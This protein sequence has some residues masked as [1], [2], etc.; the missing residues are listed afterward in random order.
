MSDYN[1]RPDWREIDRKKDKSRHYG[2]HEEIHQTGQRPNANRWEM[3]RRK[4]ALDRLFRG[5]KG[6]LEHDRLLNKIHKSYK[7]GSF[8][9][10]IK[11]YIDKYGM[12][13]DVSTLLIILDS[14]SPEYVNGAMIKLGSIFE[15]LTSRQKDDVKR[16]LSIIRMADRSSDVRERADE[17]LNGL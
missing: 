12:P 5:E 15:G 2:R 9:P 1:D 3:G 4:D 6:T 8:I 17:I 13:D 16:K 11:A 10:N 7:T 14:G